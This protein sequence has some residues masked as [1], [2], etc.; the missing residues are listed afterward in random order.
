M[1]CLMRRALRLRSGCG[2]SRRG[3][4]LELDA[5]REAPLE[6]RNQVRR[7]RHVE[8]AGGDEEDVIGPHHAVLGRHGGAPRRSAGGLAGRPR[9]D[10]SGPCP[11]SR[12][13]ILSISSRNTMPE[14]WT[15]RMA[16]AGDLVHVDELLR[17]FL[18][19]QAPRLRRPGPS[20]A[21]CASAA[22][23]P[24]HLAQI[25]VHLAHARPG[26]HLHHRACPG[27]APPARSGGRRGGPARSC[28]RSF[29]RVAAPLA[30]AETGSRLPSPTASRMRARGRRSSRSR[31]SGR[32]R[33]A[34][35]DALRPSRS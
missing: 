23:C 35:G 20:G 6:L 28:S 10:T 32:L 15:R 8:R 14:S 21:S 13:A 4:R 12:P 34:L 5:D 24:E 1:Y 17:L 3:E 9:A 16:W 27:P 22:C 31:S 30:S 11:R 33:G 26:E 19:E 7:L 25:L 18:D 2:R 29:S